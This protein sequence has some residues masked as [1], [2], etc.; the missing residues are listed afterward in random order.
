MNFIKFLLNLGYVPVDPNV[1]QER[2][3]ILELKYQ[4]LLALAAE[5]R[6][7]LDDN[8]RL[9]QFYMDVKEMEQSFK[10]MEKILASPDVGHDVTSVHLLLSKHKVFNF[11]CIENTKLLICSEC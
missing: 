6:A 3:K 4:E 8:R 9:W 1:V 5:R 10:E 11:C 7:R 2:Q